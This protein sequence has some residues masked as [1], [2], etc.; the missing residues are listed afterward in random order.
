MALFDMTNFVYLPG[1]E[2]L[3]TT[4][5]PLGRELLRSGVA[6]RERLE[7]L[8]ENPLVYAGKALHYLPLSCMGQGVEAVR[9]LVKGL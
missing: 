9:E 2:R 5:T 4:A 7:E 1:G 6:T 8:R 3:D